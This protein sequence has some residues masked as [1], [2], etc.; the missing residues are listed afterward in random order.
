MLIF[1]WLYDLVMERAERAFLGS[2]RRATISPVRG[3]ALEIGAGTGLDFGYYRRDTRVVATDP[4]MHMLTRARVRARS[5]APQILL[6]AADAEALPFRSSAFDGAVVGLAL[7]TIPQPEQALAELQ[8]TLRPGSHVRL[9]EH[10]RV[11]HPLWGRL[12]DRLTPLWRR[13]AGG[14]R[15]NRR[16]ALTVAESGLVLESVEPHLG[17]YIQRIVARVPDRAMPEARRRPPSA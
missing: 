8:R 6:V 9:L 4:D 14:C 2:L 12:Q 7:C 11:D 15:L 17:G 5:A 16:T 3:L 10:V 1:P 13:M